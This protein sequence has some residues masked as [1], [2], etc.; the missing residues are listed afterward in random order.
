MLGIH[1]ALDQPGRI[2][3]PGLEVRADAAQHHPQHV[4]GQVVAAYRAADSPSRS[5]SRSA[6]TQPAVCSRIRASKNPNLRHTARASDARLICSSP[7]PSNKPRIA[8]IDSGCANVRLIWFCL[9]I[10]QR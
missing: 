1:E 5:N 6:L 4:R 10:P 2:A 7:P 9:S 8:S 3:V